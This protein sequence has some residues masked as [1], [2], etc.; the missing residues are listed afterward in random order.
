MEFSDMSKVPEVAPKLILRT[1]KWLASQQLEDGSWK[2]D[3]QFIN[4]GATNRYNS[5]VLRI[6]AYLSW[7]LRDTGYQAPAVEKAK[8]FIS[9][10]MASKIDPYTLAVVTTLATASKQTPEF[11]PQPIRMPRD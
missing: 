2:P 3:T 11:T 8:Q 1:T 7:A 4:E 9:K 10:R 6:T 5:D